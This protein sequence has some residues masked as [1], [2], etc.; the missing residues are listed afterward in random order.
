MQKMI[1]DIK[2]NYLDV[3]FISLEV[4]KS[5]LKAQKLYEKFDFYSYTTK[6][7]YYED[8]EDAILMG[9]NM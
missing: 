6:Q 4:R 8:G 5:N 9:R 2:E 3:F 7:N 1:D